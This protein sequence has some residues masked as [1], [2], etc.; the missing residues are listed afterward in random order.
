MKR[1][2]TTAIAL[3]LAALTGCGGQS[4]GQSQQAT[5]VAQ[6]VAAV[7]TTTPA[8]APGATPTEPPAPTSEPP[9]EPP[10]EPPAPTSEPPAPTREPPAPTSEPPTEAPTATS[11]PPTPTEV[12]VVAAVVPF[13]GSAE[14]LDGGVLAPGY[15]AFPDVFREV[16]AFRV[17]VRD[18]GAGEQDGAGVQSVSYT[19]TRN[20][21]DGSA[22]QVYEK[23]ES[24]P[25]YCMT[26]GDDPGCSPIALTP[27][28]VWPNGA[29]IIDGE[30]HVEIAVVANNPDK[31]AFWNFDF[32]IKL[33]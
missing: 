14:G 8:G 1:R 15:Q 12:R 30:Y 19:I 23:T 17:V 16:L 24:S 18:L 21:E 2:L 28:A 9:T 32:V 6:T 4:A 31:F 3:A 29:P 7:L 25:A 10:T 26:G 5:S 22:S 27:G 20:E 11:E 33:Q 13:G